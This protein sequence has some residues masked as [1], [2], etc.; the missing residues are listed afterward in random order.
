MRHKEPD[1]R[2]TAAGVLPTFDRS[3]LAAVA[4]ADALRDSSHEV[5]AA[6]ATALA[7]YAGVDDETIVHDLTDALKD[8]VRLVAFSAARSLTFYGSA[9]ESAT[10]MLLKRLRR[11]LVEC[12]DDDATMIMGALNAIDRD[13][14]SRV[15]EYFSDADSEFRDFSLELIEQLEASS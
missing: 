1:V 6:A 15:T 11:A 2:A 13:V 14:R 4:L 8:D 12:R 9:A 5:R 7:H 3:Q 10:K